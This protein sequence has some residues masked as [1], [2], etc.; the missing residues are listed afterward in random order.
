MFVKIN[1]YKDSY[2]FSD[3]ARQRPPIAVINVT[4][5]V[6]VLPS[7]SS[8]HSPGFAEIFL[9]LLSVVL[10][11]GNTIEL[12]VGRQSLLSGGI[13]LVAM[14]DLHFSSSFVLRSTLYPSG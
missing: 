14:C 11:G 10:P 7:N 13:V 1:T 2:E 9:Q 6:V 8:S 4:P 12:S 5:R 3:V